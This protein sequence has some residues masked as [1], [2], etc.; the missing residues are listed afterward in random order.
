MPP[1]G[2]LNMTASTS[3]VRMDVGRDDVHTLKTR[4]SWGNE[5]KSHTRKIRVFL[6][7]QFLGRGSD[8]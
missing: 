6:F 1:P 5:K 7:L 8:E 3:I 4:D 2:N